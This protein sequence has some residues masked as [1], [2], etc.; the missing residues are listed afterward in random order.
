MI[1]QLTNAIG[2]G[3][4]TLMNLVP[5]PGRLTIIPVKQYSP[6]PEPAGVPYV[7]MFNPENWELQEEQL[8]ERTQA[9]GQIRQEQQPQSIKAKK[10][11]F[12][13][14]I[15]GTGASGERREVL[16]DVESL[17]RTLGYNGDTH[18]PNKLFIIWGSQF[19]QCVMRTSR[20]RYTLFRPNGT[21]LRATV[22]LEFIEDTPRVLE[23]LLAN[24]QS[25]DLTRVRMVKQDERLDNLCNLVYDHPRFLLEVAKANSLTS[26]RQ[27]PVGRELIFPPIEK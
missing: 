6:N 8:F 10:L 20:V 5:A 23:V 22:S 24:N 12:E 17:R 4:G 7:A 19:F 1:D 11:A 15:D 25:A 14:L 27:L 13:L 21:P 26:F 16:G 3:V 18:S 2:G 9:T